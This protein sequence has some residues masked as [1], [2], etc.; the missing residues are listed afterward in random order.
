LASARG[1]SHPTPQTP[2]RRFAPPITFPFL[3]ACTCLGVSHAYDSAPDGERTKTQICFYH[4]SKSITS[5]GASNSHCAWAS[6]RPPPGIKVEAD[7]AQQWVQ[8]CRGVALA[9]SCSTEANVTLSLQQRVS[10]GH[11]FWGGLIKVINMPP[12]HTQLVPNGVPP[13]PRL[14]L[15]TCTSTS[16]ISRR[17]GRL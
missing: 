7:I 17:A 12:S 1:P 8:S 15:A 10:K 6:F 9:S 4:F 11:I 16:S 3:D 13:R 2:M 14:P 5:R